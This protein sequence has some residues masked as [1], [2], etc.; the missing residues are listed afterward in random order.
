VSSERE[1]TGLMNPLRGGLKKGMA[2]TLAPGEEV[3]AV[4]AGSSGEALV[5]TGERAVTLK[6]GLLAGAP[7]GWKAN[8]IPYGEAIAVRLTGGG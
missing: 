8:S 4:L 1:K 6:A 3:L 7:F 2:A 5:L